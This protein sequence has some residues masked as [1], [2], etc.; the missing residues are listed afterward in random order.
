MSSKKVREHVYGAGRY[1]FYAVMMIKN[2][3][4]RHAIISDIC[5]GTVGNDVKKLITMGHDVILL[6][7][8]DANGSPTCFEAIEYN[9]AFSEAQCRRK[10]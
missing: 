4:Q 6:Q 7:W 1:D 8:N 2:K 5:Q 10:P 9:S 3:V